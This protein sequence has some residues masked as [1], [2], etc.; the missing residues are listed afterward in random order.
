MAD[1]FSRLF[2]HDT[3]RS[4]QFGRGI[5]AEIHPDEPDLYNTSMDAFEAGEVLEAYDTFLQS[6]QTFR[7]GKPND[8]ITIERG[9]DA[10]TFVLTQGSLIVNGRVTGRVFEARALIADASRTN[11]AVKRRLIERNY[12]LTY[13]RYAIHDDKLYL[14]LYLD[15]TTMS[16]QKV[17][18][19]LRELALNGDYEKE[20]IVSEFDG[21]SLLETDH[22]TSLDEAE[23]R[24]KYDVLKRWV[25]ACKETIRHLPANDNAGMIAFTYLTLLMQVDYLIVPRH[26]TGREIMRHVN[27]YFADDEKG[28]DEKNRELENFVASL[29]ELEYERFA[30]EL[31]PLVQTFSPMERASH[32]EIATFIEET[33]TKVRWYKSNRYSRVIMTIYRY[34]PL[35]LLFNFGVHPSLQ[36]LLHLIVEIHHG[37][38]FAELGFTPLYD[39]QSNRF[40]RRTI[41]ARIGRCIRPYQDQFPQL[42]EFSSNLNFADLEKFSYSYLLQL[43]HLDY[44]EL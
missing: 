31:Y 20:F 23:K 19:P 14:K 25:A 34:I 4:Y 1:W 24:L 43:K 42:E 21:A 27:D 2:S 11:V 39:P 18:Y 13:V 33:F 16:P 10:L 36:A 32:E 38:Y 41:L 7:N 37:D 35:Y 8:N 17:F 9:E 3:P 26:K 30:S 22:V 15:N 44:S 40:D 28:V 12:Q 5:N 6:L 29:G